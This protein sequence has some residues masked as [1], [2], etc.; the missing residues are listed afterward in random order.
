[1]CVPSMALV[2]NFTSSPKGSGLA[3]IRT[4]SKIN[5]PL[6]MKKGVSIGW[7]LSISSVI[8]SLFLWY[9]LVYMSSL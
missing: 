7:Y 8:L 1:M 5:C 2:L 9:S 6:K 4:N 3:S